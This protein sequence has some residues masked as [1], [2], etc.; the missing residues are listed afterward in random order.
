MLR[1]ISYIGDRL[2]RGWWDLLLQFGLFFVAYQCYGLVRGLVDG[3][4]DLAF[5]NADRIIDLERSTGTFFE[6]SLQQSLLD[7][8]WIID[9]AN[10]L[11]LNTHFTITIA[12][13]AWLY[14]FHNEN[15]YFVRNMFMVAMVLAL[16]G[17]ALYPTAPPRLLPGD[18][19]VDTIA[20]I[21]GTA[22]DSKTASLLV[23][24]YAAVPSMH[25]GF[26][27]MIGATAFALVKNPARWLWLL[28]PVLVF[29]VIVVTA[30]HYWLDAAAGALVAAVSALVAARVLAPVRPGHWSFRPAPAEPAPAEAP[31]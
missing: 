11:Y 29:F 15:F 22:Q 5:A 25:I 16:I 6:S 19:F 8:G 7:N 14:L 9:I 26:S 4:A 3:K 1:P 28:Y 24:K 30:N 21:T 27:T 17:Y 13:L 12:F 18:M 23:N 31:A 10:W 2:P 20:S